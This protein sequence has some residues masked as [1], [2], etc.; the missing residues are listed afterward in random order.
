MMISATSLLVL[1]GASRLALGQQCEHQ[2]DGPFADHEVDGVPYLQVRQA[3]APPPL[4]IRPLIINGPSENRVDLIFFGDGY[5]EDEKDK[6][7]E[8]AMFQATNLTDG[9]TFADVLPL[10]NFWAGFSPSAESGIGVGG[11]ARD[12]VYGLYR[13][14]TELR[15]VYYAYPQ[16]ARAA[17]QSTDATKPRNM[18]ADLST[19]GSVVT[20]SPN[21]GPA[22]LR[23]ELGH[24]IIGVGEEYDGGTVYRGVNAARGPGSVPWSQWYTDPAV[25]P[26]IQRSNMPI[27]AYPWT[28]LNTTSA[29]S[30]TFSSAGTYDSHMLQFSVSG[31]TATTDLRVEIDGRDVGWEYN[32]IVGMDRWIYNI[33]FDEA[34]APGPHNL[35]FVLLNDDVQGTAQ[36]CNLQIL[37]YGDESEFEFTEGHHSLYPTYSASNA[38]TYRPT[39][40]LCLMRT[41]HSVDFCDAC[42]EGLWWSLLRPLN[43]IDGITQRARTD[44][45]TNVTLELLP[46][47]QFREIPNS[48][49]E[50]YTIQW[51]DSDGGVLAE[52]ANSTTALISQELGEVEVE[53]RFSTEQVRLD[54][55]NVMLERETIEVQTCGQRR[56]EPAKL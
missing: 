7:F 25:E 43:L 30:R 8:D 1:A 38:T 3:T 33:R 31:V 42:I 35:T 2:W 51:F 4:E 6:F 52:W 21:N 28:L 49:E 55:Q 19:P 27:Q 56:S 5:T 45:V 48:A 44:G 20:A 24:S 17:C 11:V 37:E 15:G 9:Q 53:V 41:M 10:M 32:Q 50:S 22:V 23:H 34:L 39:D 40:R 36:L 13:D 12:T 26:R 18:Y 54:P 14:G 47:A 29:W 46:L 16:V